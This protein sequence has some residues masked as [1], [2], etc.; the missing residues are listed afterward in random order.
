MKYLL[1]CYAM[2][3]VITCVLYNVRRV[4]LLLGVLISRIHVI[5]ALTA[6][7]VPILLLSRLKKFSRI[8]EVLLTGC[9]GRS[10]AIRLTSIQS[11]I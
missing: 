5:I 10:N 1:R 3:R 4:E 8:N 11:I 7:Y 9:S 6:E 2:R